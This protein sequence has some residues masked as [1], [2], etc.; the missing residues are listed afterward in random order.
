V[1]RRARL[2]V[3]G[4]IQ[5]RGRSP[6]RGGGGPRGRRARHHRRRAPERLP[7]RPHREHVHRPQVGR[8]GAPAQGP[9][10]DQRPFR[11]RDPL[12]PHAQEK[13]QSAR[14]Q[15]PGGAL[16]RHTQGAV[17]VRL[18]LGTEVRHRGDLARHPPG[19]LE[20]QPACECLRCPGPRAR[21]DGH[22]FAFPRARK[23]RPPRGDAVAGFL[24]RRGR[25]FRRR[26]E[27]DDHAAQA[28][29][30]ERTGGPAPLRPRGR[31]HGPGWKG[32]RQLAQEDR[33][34][35]NRARPAQGQVGR[36]VPVCRQRPAGL[37]ERCQ[38][39]PG[40]HLCGRPEPT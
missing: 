19:G 31:R 30:A 5:R 37:R 36:V 21:R 9:Q 22:P 17:P 35:D 16:H 33:P 26:W 1:D 39:D 6:G 7:G 8:Q 12:H 3:R 34:A 23:A 28:L 24:G 32:D 15:R 29:V 11:Q 4:R 20:R 38:L 27:G 18:G 2:G 14:H 40:E 13:S 25:G 10:H